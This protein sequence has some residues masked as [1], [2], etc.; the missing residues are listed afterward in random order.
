MSVLWGL[1][2]SGEHQGNPWHPQYPKSASHSVS[3]SIRQKSFPL[4]AGMQFQYFYSTLLNCWQQSILLKVSFYLLFTFYFFSHIFFFSFSSRISTQKVRCPTAKHTQSRLIQ[5]R[6]LWEL[7]EGLERKDTDQHAR[8]ILSQAGCRHRGTWQTQICF[9]GHGDTSCGQQRHI[10][11]GKTSLREKLWWKESG[12][13]DCL[14]GEMWHCYIWQR[15]AAL[16][17]K[18]CNSLIARCSHS[19]FCSVWAWPTSLFFHAVYNPFR[20]L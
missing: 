16:V 1:G 20:D 19:G 8:S 3:A 15:G 17:S 2:H 4:G 11:C 12:I 9:H 13:K 18:Q 7:Q 6:Q 10:G 14:A 5:P